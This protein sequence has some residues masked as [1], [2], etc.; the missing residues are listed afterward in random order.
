VAQSQQQMTPEQ[1]SQP[2]QIESQQMTPQQ[3]PVEQ[4]FQDQQLS[5][6]PAPA[7]SV[8]AADDK[9]ENLSLGGDP[10]AMSAAPVMAS[11]ANPS[12]VMN[13]VVPVESTGAAI[14]AAAMA[15]TPVIPTIV[16]STPV[17]ATASPAAAGQPTLLSE[18]EDPEEIEAVD[19]PV[20]ELNSLNIPSEITQS[21]G[22]SQQATTSKGNI[23]LAIDE[24][25]VK[26]IS[27][28][29]LAVPAAQSEQPVQPSVA[30]SS[31]AASASTD[32]TSAPVD[33]A[34]TNSS[35]ESSIKVTT[36]EDPNLL[37]ANTPIDTYMK[38]AE[39][40]DASDIHFTAKYPVM[41]RVNGQ[42]K[43]VS[44]TL[45]REQSHDL[46]LQLLSEERKKIFL[47]DKEVD[48]SFTSSTD[49]R[50]RVNL[51]TDRDNSAGALRLIAKHIRTMKE[52]EL[53]E[54]FYEVVEEPHG[55]VLLVGPTGSGKSTT[56]AAMLNHINL[57]KAE[58]IL[59]IED[60]IEYVYPVGKSIVNQRE[61][62]ADTKSWQ[63]ALKS[64]LREDPN[65]VLVGEMRDL[66]TIESTITIAE[67]GHLTFATLHTNSAAQAVDRIIDVFPEG[68]K[69]Q[70]RAQLANVLTAVISQ[71]LIPVQQGGR[72]AALEVMLGTVAVRNAIRE[73]KTYQIDNIIQTSG[74]L[75]M[76]TL[77]KS[78]VGMVKKGYISRE[79]A[80]SYSSKPDEIE[81]L[82]NKL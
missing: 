14:P 58:H 41:F 78:L 25:G 31:A 60:P 74:D 54:V 42:L 10:S 46:A 2:Q 22:L 37:P 77:E 62:S 3:M 5:G 66:S 29:A 65:I 9:D 27:G 47:T 56:L 15:T 63:A 13:S 8:I 32:T 53:P 67:T 44:N 55:L 71:R 23:E 39:Q 4:Q 6:Q 18:D 57:N 19:Y 40:Q 24:D 76:L 36:Q 72:R 82:L 69:D 33:S 16:A 35:P 28:P 26:T 52:L 43:A 59:T 38:L 12:P 7:G 80:K 48:F 34:V 11:M 79:A 68:A 75:G 51:F 73:G 1:M 50:F 20:G 49:T 45:T 21:S 17:A 70:I 64:A 61:V 81:S 30:A